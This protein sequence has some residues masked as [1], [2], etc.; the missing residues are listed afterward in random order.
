MLTVVGHVERRVVLEVGAYAGRVDDGIDAQRL[1]DFLRPDAAELQDPGG[2][3]RSSGQYDILRS[4]KLR[5]LSAAAG[6]HYAPGGVT[7]EIYPR[8]VVPH[9]QVEVR[10]VAS[11]GVVCR[12]GGG[13]NGLGPVRVLWKPRDSHVLAIGAVFEVVCAEVSGPG[14][15]L[16][17][18][19]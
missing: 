13:A 12:L 15:R 9:K 3:H 2:I 1:E 6:H 17:L 19:G 18:W 5:A 11:G 7:L 10:P 8:A 14:L 16:S 4:N